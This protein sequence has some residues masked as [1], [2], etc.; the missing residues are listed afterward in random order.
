MVVKLSDFLST[1]FVPSALDSGDVLTIVRANTIAI[2]SNTTGNYIAEITGGAG[3][4]VTGSGTHAATPTITFD[5][6]MV[7]GV[8]ATQTLT[9]KTINLTN[10][11]LSTTLGQLNAAVSGSTLVSTDGAETLTNKTIT[12]PT[13]TTPV[14]S[15]GSITDLTTFGLRDVTTAAYETR[16]VSNNA[17]PALSADRTLTLD[18][19]NANRTVSLTGNLVLGGTFT[20]SGAHAT[21]LTTSGTTALTLPTSGT[22]VTKDDSGDFSAGLITADFDRSAN[23]TVTAGTYGSAS[24]V[25]I[26]TVDSSGFIDS[27]GS[28]SVAG[29][30]SLAF[31]SATHTFTINT[32]DGGSFSEVVQTRMPGTSG[33]FGSASQVPII[34]VNQ[35]GLVDSISEVS[36]AGVSSL[37]FDSAT[38]TFTINTADGGS[39][40]E[41]VQTKMPG[42]SGTFG[43]ASLVPI[44]TVNQYG[45]VD[46]ISTV[47]VAGVSTFD[48]DSANGKIT[49]GTAD[50]GTFQQV[51]TLDPYTTTDLSE[52]TNLYYT[53]V[54]ADSD[55]KN[56]ISVT[57]LGGDG[58]LT[59]S[60]ATGVITYTGPSASEVRSRFSAG[61]GI[62]LTDG[63]ISNTG[64]LS[65][66]GNTGAITAGQL[67]TALKTVD[68]NGSGLN[69]D[70]LDG[71][72]GS[73][74]LRSD[75][76]D[77]FTGDTITFTSTSVSP[78]VFMSGN[79]GASSYN[80]IIKGSNDIGTGAV[81][82]I[83]GSTRTADGG[84]NTYTIRNDIG[85]IRLGRSSQTTS[86]EGSGDLTYNSNEVWHAGNDGS[87]ST[88]DADLLDGQEGTY[89]R[90]DVYD[91]SGT[92]LN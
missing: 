54:R 5:S 85:P 59:Y 27:I 39:F 76:D 15:A 52:G 56:A 62:G 74:Y 55:A 31:D 21:T 92:L 50:G 3:I 24:L 32:A 58:S 73:S 8:N 18:V 90:I 25:P 6:S 16:I 12:S 11:T 40:T 71:V 29:V 30:A 9:N 84:A 42:S 17:S 13:I 14:I 53:T 64:V 68:S 67:L 36:V 37:A 2:D 20:T 38:H 47:S 44:V 80:Y 46:S 41:I 43:S 35:Y 60:A 78:K 72:Q 63:E 49:I 28:V 45:L 34:T 79:G 77:N 87:G 82:F 26:L 4:T 23:T 33:A 61:T 66:N 75:A 88:L 86:I 22:V 65:V 89:Y 51:I 70:T 81:H 19:N 91:A 57:D 48:F 7:V 69:A 10:N 83:N 1:N